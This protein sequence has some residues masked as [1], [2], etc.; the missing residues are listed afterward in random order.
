MDNYVSPFTIT[1][2]MLEYVSKI[3]EKIGKM[4][5]YTN[6]NKMLNLRKNNKIRSIHSSLA[7]ES[8]SLT[9]EQVAAVI[10]GKLVMGPQKEI[11]EVLNAYSAYEMIGKVNPFSLEDLKKIHGM[12]TYKTVEQSGVFRSE[13]EGVFDDLGNCIHVCPPP[14]QV[15]ILMSQLFLWMKNNKNVVHPL[16]LSSVFHY[17]LVFIHPFS[18]GNGRT[19]RLWQNIILSNWKEFFEYLPIESQIKKYQ[20]EYYEAITKCNKA[21]SSNDFIEFMLKMIDDVLTE[22]IATSTKPLTEKAININKLLNVIE[23]HVP[24]SASEIMEHLG[25]KSKETL[26]NVYLDPAIEEGFVE[27]T[28]PDKPT[29]KNQMYY[30]K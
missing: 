17:E 13:N 21:A 4:S 30:K 2:V 5:N 19:T 22:T 25:I 6:L 8:N 26:R 1:S 15:P 24:M 3:M 28:I 20:D 16:I 23:Y 27:L 7:I 9:L 14:E 11:Q 18:D 10:D 29:S 12:L